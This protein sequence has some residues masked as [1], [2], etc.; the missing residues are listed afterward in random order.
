MQ[1]L[2]WL[3]SKVSQYL[4]THIQGLNK[5]RKQRMLSQHR[6]P[7]TR[8]G[9]QNVQNFIDNEH[10]QFKNLPNITRKMRYIT[11]TYVTFLLFQTDDSGKQ[12]ERTYQKSGNTSPSMPKSL[13]CQHTL[14]C[15]FC[16]LENLPLK[17]SSGSQANGKRTNAWL[18]SNV[19]KYN[20][21]INTVIWT[22]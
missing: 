17:Y 10:R 6:K 5:R 15:C 1:K 13:I 2:C 4:N 20:R 16:S 21:Q 7:L 3:V 18:L 9:E 8:V 14:S 19:S 12:Y 22:E 11:Q